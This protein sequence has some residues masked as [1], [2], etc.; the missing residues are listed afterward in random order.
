MTNQDSLGGTARTAL[1]VCCSPSVD[2]AAETL[3][4]LRFG[5]RAKGIVSAVPV[6]HWLPFGMQ[7]CR[8]FDKP[9]GPWFG[10]LADGIATCHPSMSPPIH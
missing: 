4:S 2:N 7:G 5:S 8:G 6:S 1:I 10:I 9:L 3:S